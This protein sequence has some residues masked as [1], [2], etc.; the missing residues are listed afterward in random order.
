MATVGTIIYHSLYEMHRDLYD[1]IMGGI[2]RQQ[3]IESW[4]KKCIRF[5]IDYIFKIVKVSDAVLPELI[6][7]LQE[8]STLL[9]SSTMLT[10]EQI[11]DKI[12]IEGVYLIGRNDSNSILYKHSRGSRV[13]EYDPTIL[14][15]LVKDCM[16][17]V[18][19]DDLA[20]NMLLFNLADQ[21]HTELLKK[22]EASN[23]HVPS[24]WSNPLSYLSNAASSVASLWRR[25]TQPVQTV[26]EDGFVVDFSEV[27][28]RFSAKVGHDITTQN[29]A[30]LKRYVMNLIEADPQYGTDD[31]TKAKRE[32]KFECIMFNINQLG[33]HNQLGEQ[34]MY[35]IIMERKPQPPQT[36]QELLQII[37][38]NIDDTAIAERGF[39][40]TVFRT[41]GKKKTKRNK[42]SKQRR[43]KRHPKNTKK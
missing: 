35:E 11:Q 25:P 2:E 39:R 24:V 22:R 7:Q 9:H 8:L 23:A 13:T 20:Q 4:R 40:K 15:L 37:D 31:S 34:Y 29:T 28:S 41:C 42:K 26:D 16:N 12:Y 32:E 27:P 43:N 1:A 10:K 3:E 36:L 30:Y 6:P 17:S 18:M 5:G 19:S 38:Q 21:K 33:G 14:G